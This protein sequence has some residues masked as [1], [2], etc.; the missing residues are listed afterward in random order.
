MHVLIGDF[1]QL[2]R[3]RGLRVSTAETLDALEALRV[4]GPGN[5][6]A[7]RDAL[8]TALIKDSRDVATFDDLFERYFTLAPDARGAA[9]EPPQPAH[10][11]GSA[12]E[13]V[14]VEDESAQASDTGGHSHDDAEHV[15]LPRIAG[16]RRGPVEDHHGDSDQLR[17]SLFAQQL[18]LTH[19]QEALQQALR[20]LTQ[21]LRIRR[22]RG[23]LNPGP[24]SPV[25]AD[26]E[27][28]VDI[29]S[30]ELTDLLNHLDELDVDPRLV[31]LLETQADRIAEGLPELIRTLLQRRREL[32]TPEDPS[33]PA[34]AFTRD[35]LRVSAGEHAQIEHAIRRLARSIRGAATRRQRRDRVGKIDLPHTLR[36]NLRYDGVPFEPVLRNRQQHRPRLVVLCDVSLSTRNL[37]RFWLQLLHQTQRLFSQVRT[38]VYVAD[39]TEVTDALE[40][41]PLEQAVQAL[42]SGQFLDVDV[43][44]DFGRVAEIFCTHHLDTVTRRSTV[45]ILGDGRN[46]GRPPNERA[47]NE[48]AQ[49]ARQVIWMTPEPRWGWSLGDCAMPRYAPFCDRV[50]VVRTA[51]HLGAVA[52]TRT[53]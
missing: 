51:E 47:L 36:R 46:N 8:R 11:H 16:Q 27:L 40:S 5:R 2:L 19:R 22:A 15:Q 26:A 13:R 7:V 45:V 17:L 23:V 21:Q 38:F 12:L 39:I 42:F 43:N 35:L 10:E 37:A 33:G 49:Q 41:K 31:G 52:D 48:I 30:V 6:A 34:D 4:V 9:A 24:L 14:S 18:L 20:H 28:P 25:A 1:V 29:S 50:E 32:D 53:P 3:R 44:S